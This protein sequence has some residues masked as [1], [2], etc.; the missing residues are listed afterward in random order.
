MGDLLLPSGFVRIAVQ[1][2]A[3]AERDARVPTVEAW[4]VRVTTR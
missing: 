4:H 3:T 2:L 1:E